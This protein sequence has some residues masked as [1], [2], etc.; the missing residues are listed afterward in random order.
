MKPV[1]LSLVT[2]LSLSAIGC[3]LPLQSAN[4]PTTYRGQQVV[5]RLGR[6]CEEDAQKQNLVYLGRRYSQGT[7]KTGITWVEVYGKR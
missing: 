6:L 3:A 2:L 1:V 7:G 5:T 4:P